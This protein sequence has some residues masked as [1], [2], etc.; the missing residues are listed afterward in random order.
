MQK[1]GMGIRGAKNEANARH[2]SAKER[3]R[4][5]VTSMG[6]TEHNTVKLCS[7]GGQLRHDFEINP[8]DSLQMAEDSYA[9]GEMP[10]ALFD[11]KRAIHSQI[12][13]ALLS[14]GYSLEKKEMKW[15]LNMM[16]RCGFIAPRI[17]KRVSDAR[18]LLEHEY[19][20]PSKQ[21]VEESLNI[22]A[23]F[24]GAT[25]RHLDLFEHEFNVG[26]E[27]EQIDEFDF[28]N[29]LF[30]HFDEGR[31]YF[32]IIACQDVQ[33]NTF[34]VAKRVLGKIRIGVNDEIFPEVV[35]LTVAGDHE[36]KVRQALRELFAVLAR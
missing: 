15:K 1:P 25:R 7:G 5:V 22:A 9:K 16:A 12:D 21:Q 30:F 33:P 4:K 32:R 14:L 29:E 8:D 28:S 20:A 24:I 31:H 36:G 13:Q 34:G 18:N 2:T 11:A 3:L 27:D 26:K 6:F 35:R 23:L 10:H 19:R 17:M